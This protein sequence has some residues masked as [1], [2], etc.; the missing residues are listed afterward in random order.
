MRRLLII[1]TA[2]TL[3]VLPV[4][5][6]TQTTA[7]QSEASATIVEPYN[8]GQGTLPSDWDTYLT[9]LKQHLHPGTVTSAR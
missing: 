5:S 2:C 4:A 8:G 7:P 9:F 1:M 6:R 3:C